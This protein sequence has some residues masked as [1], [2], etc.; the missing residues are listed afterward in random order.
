LKPEHVKAQGI[1][2][3][4][5]SVFN[6]YKTVSTYLGIAYPINRYQKVSLQ[7]E[8]LKTILSDFKTYDQLE[9]GGYTELYG[10]RFKY[11]FD[12][13][14]YV[15]DYPLRGVNA[16]FVAETY[17]R[18]GQAGPLYPKLNLELKSYTP[19]VKDIVIAL[20]LNA[21]TTIFESTDPQERGRTNLIGGVDNWVFFDNKF[22]QNLGAEATFSGRPEGYNFLN[23]VT[24]VRGYSY[25]A[26]QGRHYAVGN[27][28]IRLPLKRIFNVGLNT[29]Y[30][31]NLLFVGFF[32]MGMAWN[33]GNPFS[34]TAISRTD[35]FSQGP[36]EV[37]ANRFRTPYIYSFGGGLRTILL[38]YDVKA[39]LASGVDD[40]QSQ[41]LKFLVSIGKIF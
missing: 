21:G 2:I 35:D 5:L 27:A 24:G 33:K 39:E 41:P 38:G 14:F 1:W 19:L 20:R 6:N 10:I 4:F 26:R 16:R 30:M 13:S 37:T 8:Y 25:S 3:N 40:G 31:H 34:Q 7:G 12:N 22:A 28:E 23:F 11:A 32:D 18:K 15:Q 17:F 36:F 9:L 29:R